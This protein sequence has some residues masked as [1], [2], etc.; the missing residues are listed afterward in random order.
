MLHVHVCT[1]YSTMHYRVRGYAQRYRL[2]LQAGLTIRFDAPGSELLQS[3]QVA[4]AAG[5]HDRRPPPEVLDHQAGPQL[6]ELGNHGLVVQ[7]H[8]H[9]QGGLPRGRVWKVAGFSAR[10]LVS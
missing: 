9:V 6:Q 4:V 8:R 5:G 3:L 10:I 1:Q 2:E 7:G